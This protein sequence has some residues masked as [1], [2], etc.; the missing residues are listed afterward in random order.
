MILFKEELVF[1]DVFGEV[2]FGWEW[3][4]EFEWVVD[5]YDGG[6]R[7]GGLKG[8]EDGEV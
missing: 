7:G 3:G 6:G 4:C 1:E 8:E 5:D 2:G